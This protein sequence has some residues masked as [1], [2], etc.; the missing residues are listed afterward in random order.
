MKIKVGD[1][2]VG[3]VAQIKR[4]ILLSDTSMEPRYIL[5]DKRRFSEL[6]VPNNEIG[7]L[8]GGS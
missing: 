6:A 2:I 1:G 3:R 8:I 4:P 5:D 7:R